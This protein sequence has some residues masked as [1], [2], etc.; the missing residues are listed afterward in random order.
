LGGVD[1]AALRQAEAAAYAHGKTD[2]YADAIKGVAAESAVVI[3][4]LDRARSAAAQLEHWSKQPTPAAAAPQAPGIVGIA[5]RGPINPT[6]VAPAKVVAKIMRGDISP[7]VRKILD[8]VHRAFPVALSFEAAALRAGV[9]RRSSAYRSYRQ[10]VEASL[11]VERR[12]DGKLQSAA[13]YANPVEGG[14]DPIEAFAGRLPPSYAGMLRAIA[15]AHAPMTK[16]DVAAA[17][18]VSPTSSGLSSGLRELMA[19][20]LVVKVGD[21]YAIHG[22]L[23]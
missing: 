19:L 3:Q 7:T 20:S 12:A 11:E 15:A 16:D 2:G 10:Q 6:I 13:G 5:Q 23:R 17:A 14:A 4:A 21:G 18:N 22:D 8:E 9:S 1:Q